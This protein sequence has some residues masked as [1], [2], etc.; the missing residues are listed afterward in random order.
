MKDEKRSLLIWPRGRINAFTLAGAM[1]NSESK[2]ILAY[3]SPV[4]H[5][6]LKVCCGRAMW[7]YRD[8]LVRLAP[9]QGNTEVREARQ[10]ASEVVKLVMRLLYRARFRD[11]AQGWAAGRQELLDAGEQ[12]KGACTSEVEKGQSGWEGIDMQPPAAIDGVR[13]DRGAAFSGGSQIG[14][15]FHSPK[16]Q[17]SALG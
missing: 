17:W 1:G 9:H 6:H 5:L 7:P 10:V 12:W 3:V 13:L 4:Q 8:G 16:A 11:Q 2:L 15:T 14:A